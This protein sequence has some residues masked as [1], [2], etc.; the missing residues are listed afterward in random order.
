MKE[1]VEVQRQAEKDSSD[2]GKQVKQL[3]AELEEQVNRSIELEQ[4]QRNESRD[5]RQQI[6]SLE[7]QMENN[8]KFLD[9][10][11]D[12][13]RVKGRCFHKRFQTT[14]LKGDIFYRQV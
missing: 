2:L 9:V 14:Q 8:R 11:H 7:K 5:L 13:T 3:E 6:Q 4:A 12:Y 10:S 1:K